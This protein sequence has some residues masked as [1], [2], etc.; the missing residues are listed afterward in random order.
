MSSKEFR[1]PMI[2][3][4]T[5]MNTTFQYPRWSGEYAYFFGFGTVKSIG[6]IGYR[7]SKKSIKGH[8]TYKNAGDSPVLKFTLDPNGYLRPH[9]LLTANMNITVQVG[10]MNCRNQHSEFNSE[11]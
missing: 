5:G 10:A 2:Q 4:D 7:Q 9:F 8:R 3:P 6:T 11:K 1:F